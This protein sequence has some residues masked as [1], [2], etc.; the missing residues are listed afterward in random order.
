M[1]RKKVNFFYL[2][3]F[4]IVLGMK[5]F[6]SRADSNDLEWILAPTAWWVRILGGIPFE[7][8][9]EI[10]YVNHA[11]RFIIA[12]SCSGVQFMLITA[13]TLIFSFVQQMKTLRKGFCWIA[14]SLGLSYLLTVFVNGIRITTAI[15][16]PICLEKSGVLNGWLTP[17]R[18]HTLIGIVI[19]FTSLCVI[20]LMTGFIFRKLGQGGFP[21]PAKPHRGIIG[22]YV[23]P[24]FWYFFIAVGL[25]FLNQ[26]FRGNGEKF[27][28]YTLLIT[29]GCFSIV[30]LFYLISS[31]VQKRFSR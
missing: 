20:Y 7:N 17:E 23:P 14:T 6:Y 16:L 24:L 29:G 31:I 28:E 21:S 12:P 5:F 10:G 11:F 26:A 22:K 19:Y 8:E 25:P 13:A 2:I 27:G 1:T 15:Y 18:L 9:P 3:G 4:V 30:F